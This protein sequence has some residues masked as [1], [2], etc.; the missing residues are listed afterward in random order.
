MACKLHA[1]IDTVQQIIIPGLRDM[2][3]WYEIESIYAVYPYTRF[4]NIVIS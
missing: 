2:M 1:G 4:L 3:Y